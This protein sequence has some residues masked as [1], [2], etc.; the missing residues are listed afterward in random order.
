LPKNT[1]TRA[2]DIVLKKVDDAQERADKS[3]VPQFLSERDG[4]G[5]KTALSK[6]YRILGIVPEHLK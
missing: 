3:R 1:Y 6:L 2:V 4:R 5:Q